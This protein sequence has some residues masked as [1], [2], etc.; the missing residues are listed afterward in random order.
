MK[1]LNHHS[2]YMNSGFA[3][4]VGGDYPIKYFVLNG[5]DF[6]WGA[7]PNGYFKE[8]EGQASIK[9]CLEPRWSLHALI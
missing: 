3:P 9:T 4:Y 8:K 6:L 5:E 2:V 7:L 1:T